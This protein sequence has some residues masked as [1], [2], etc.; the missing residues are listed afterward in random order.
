M[1][2]PERIGSWWIQLGTS[3]I[4]VN[5]KHLGNDVWSLA[6][7]SKLLAK[8]RGLRVLWVVEFATNDG[9]KQKNPGKST[10]VVGLISPF[11]EEFK[12]SYNNVK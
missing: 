4:W 12:T 9:T 7:W 5:L 2:S 10:D 6:L 1:P 11:K 3:W 8:E